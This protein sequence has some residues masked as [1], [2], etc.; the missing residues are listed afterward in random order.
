MVKRTTIEIDEDL[1]ARAKL[2]L[3]RHT[4]RE[5]VEEA[6]RLATDVAET[7]KAARAQGQLRY[8]QRLSKRADPAVLR[9][10]SMWR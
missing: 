1:L 6:L 3:G 8:L 5:T 4:T 7:G 9:S 2:A 10:D